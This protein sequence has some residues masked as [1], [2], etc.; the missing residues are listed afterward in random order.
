[1][2]HDCRTKIV[3][4][5]GPACD[6]PGVLDRML[7]AG[8]DVAR[9]NFSHGTHDDHRR[10]IGTLRTL[11]ARRGQPLAVLADLQGPKIRFGNTPD[12]K[13]IVLRRRDRI[14]IVTGGPPPTG[15][16]IATP[17]RR[18]A[19]DARPGD[20][21]LAGDGVP[22]LVVRRVRS[23]R[24]TCEVVSPGTLRP[25]QGMNLPGTR[26]VTPA[27]TPK[28]AD[29]LACAIRLGA[30]YVALSFVRRASD[31]L[32]LK[33]RLARHRARI[34][35]IA[36]IEKPEAVEAIEGILAAADGIMVAR[37]DLGI[38]LAPEK[39]PPVQ[40]RLIAAAN[41]RGIP[42]ITATQMLESMLESPRPTRAEASDIA[43]AVV[44]GTDAVMLSGETAI[45]R[46]PV[47][48]VAT[49][50]AIAQ[51]AETVPAP[52]PPGIEPCETGFTCTVVRA[53]A[54]AA[55]DRRV[56]ALAAY[57]RSGRTALLLAKLRPGKPLY[58]LTPD[59]RTVARLALVWGAIPVRVPESRST[60]EMIALGDRA[61]LKQTALR[62]GDAVVVV[63]G[64][65]HPG[66][67]DM[68]KIHRL[69]AAL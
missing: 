33:R 26:L 11:A 35:V 13:P 24:V 55:E 31:V 29:D 61:L 12:G 46:Y 17:W 65:S 54:M 59:P 10:R 32:L 22:A 3:A 2:P 15:C 4:T 38:E 39:V 36:K 66:A 28:D 7:A 18:L 47:E 34:P 27:L 41:R 60:D 43:N 69:G 53:A 51:E 30:D 14:A 21:I 40:K 67:T 8:M 57:T 1:M 6:P 48:T 42:V 68:M 19:V 56:K 25:R 45:G 44:D 37:G 49:M 23:G 50:D 63:G 58:A 62:R 5:L 9:V 16:W 64:R 20:R 52:A